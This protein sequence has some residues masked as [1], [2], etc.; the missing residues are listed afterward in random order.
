MESQ[1]R[2]SI[3]PEPEAAECPGRDGRLI[4]SACNSHHK[5]IESV[6]DCNISVDIKL[7]SADGVLF[8]A[9][10]KNLESFSE[11]FPIANSMVATDVVQ[12]QEDANVLCIILTFMHNT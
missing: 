1:P 4:Y 5:H 9:H 12:L 8:G 6:E 11:G 10:Q 7:R 3:T 2:W